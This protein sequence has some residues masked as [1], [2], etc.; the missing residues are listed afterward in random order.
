MATNLDATDKVE[1][2][3]AVKEISGAMTRI[4]AERDLIRNLKKTVVEEQE[5]D[6]K[7]LNRLVKTY[8][9]GTFQEEQEVWNEFADLYTSVVG[10]P[11]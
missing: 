6:K 1:V 2:L 10:T 3:K 5:L 11:K 9:K 7:A 8:H 4:E